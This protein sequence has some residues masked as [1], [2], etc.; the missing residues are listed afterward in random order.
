[1]EIKKKI[2]LPDDPLTRDILALLTVSSLSSREKQGWLS[3]LP[4]MKWDDK[5]ELRKNLQEQV[6]YDTELVGDAVNDF[7]S[8][9][10]M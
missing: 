8:T 3:V 10:N 2:S 5:E 9:M 1:M 7:L 4:D 6:A